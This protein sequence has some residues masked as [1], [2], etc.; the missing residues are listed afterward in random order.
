MFLQ[1]GGKGPLLAFLPG[2]SVLHNHSDH[3]VLWASGWSSSGW[4][5][6]Q[7]LPRFP[8]AGHHL[9]RQSFRKWSW[10]PEARQPPDAALAAV[11]QV[12]PGC[13][14]GLG[15]G[16]PKSGGFCLFHPE[17]SASPPAGL[18]AWCQL[19]SG[20]CMGPGLGAPI[21]SASSKSVAR[22]MLPP[23]SG[24]FP[25]KA[26]VSSPCCRRVA[27]NSPGQACRARESQVAGRS[28]RPGVA[29]PGQSLMP[30]LGVLPCKLKARP[31]QLGFAAGSEVFPRACI[32]PP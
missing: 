9:S 21:C 28:V 13:H 11:V 15:P 5:L 16:F 2:A 27:L 14:V 25:A 18:A 20:R 29:V 24:G 4:A 26:E 7:C 32:R 3:P 1:E 8:C 30:T 19:I 12:G 31:A 10:S 6:L 17:V 22:C 23:G